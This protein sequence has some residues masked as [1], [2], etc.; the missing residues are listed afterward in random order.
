MQNKS[1]GHER[2]GRKQASWG[3]GVTHPSISNPSPPSEEDSQML[4]PMF[5]LTNLHKTLVFSP[6]LCSKV[7]TNVIINTKLTWSYTL[8]PLSPGPPTKH[9][10]LWSPDY[11]YSCYVLS[12][13]HTCL[14]S[15]YVPRAPYLSILPTTHILPSPWESLCTFLEDLKSLFVVFTYLQ[16]HPPHG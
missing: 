10:M 13:H 15:L 3:V 14:S 8:R 9:R 16:S 7:S 5:S 12:G 11:S 6:A 4:N 2:G 1:E